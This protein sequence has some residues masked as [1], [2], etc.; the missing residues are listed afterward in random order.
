[1]KDEHPAESH[2]M[3]TKRED[4]ARDTAS[5]HSRSSSASSLG[6][7]LYDRKCAIVNKEIDA[8]GMGRYQWSIWLLCGFGYLLDLLW[9]QAFGLVTNPLSQEL[10]FGGTA[11]GHLLEASDRN[12]D[13]R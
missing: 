5:I 4:G 11:S 6:G 8:M 7:T 10:G 1:M 3:G 2:E 9:A 12:A 13:S